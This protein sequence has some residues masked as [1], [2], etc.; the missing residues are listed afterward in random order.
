MILWY[1]I[2]VIKRGD[3]EVPTTTTHTRKKEVLTMFATIITIIVAVPVLM[4]VIGYD[5]EDLKDWFANGRINL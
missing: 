1:N 2:Y 5:W 3:N 4:N